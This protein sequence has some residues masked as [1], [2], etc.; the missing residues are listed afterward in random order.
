MPEPTFPPPSPR[1]LSSPDFVVIGAVQ[2]A[3]V[4]A[5]NA[6]LIGTRINTRDLAVDP[7]VAAPGLAGGL[8]V[9]FRDGVLV[10]VGLS[11]EALGRLESICRK[12][13][14]D[15]TEVQEW[16]IAELELAPDGGD[17]IGPTGQIFLYDFRQERLLLVATVLARSVVLARDEV[18]VSEVFD[19]IAPLVTDL[20]LNGRV[21]FPIRS[22]M[23]LVGDVVAARHRV[24]GTT[25]VDERPDLL[26]DHPD[27]DRLYSRLDAEYELKERAQVLGRKFTVLGEFTE[28]M[29]DIV[30]DKRAYRV[31]IVIIAL[32]A[33]EI[34]L[35]LFGKSVI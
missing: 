26:W 9:A 25:Q 34:V 27:I 7:A 22:V 13:V 11:A 18:L 23:K 6:R 5:A 1:P 3:T 16:E 29:L 12:Y 33:F 10:T 28:V 14:I 8:V 32:I 21:H 2:A 4:H 17:R 20:R 31:E 35:T 19:R 30:Q 24:M 15:P